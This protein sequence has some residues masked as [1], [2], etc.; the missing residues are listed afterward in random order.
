MHARWPPGRSIFD[1]YSL[2]WRV[3]WVW[4][5]GSQRVVD[6]IV[7]H[8]LGRYRAKQVTKCNPVTQENLIFDVHSQE[9]PVPR[10]NEFVPRVGIATPQGDP[11]A[12]VSIGN[13]TALNVDAGLVG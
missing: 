9:R 12:I 11:D 4:Q 1:V 7:F 3:S 13:H 5:R 10:W 8:Q 2:C 6:R